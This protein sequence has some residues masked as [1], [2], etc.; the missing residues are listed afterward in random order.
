MVKLLKAGIFNISTIW[1]DI[2]KAIL[3][4]LTKKK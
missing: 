1:A 3:D 2:I 4:A